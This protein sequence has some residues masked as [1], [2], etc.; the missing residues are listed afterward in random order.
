[1]PMIQL[2]GT[3]SLNKTHAVN[4]D[5][6]STTLKAIQST[7]GSKCCLRREDEETVNG[8]EREREREKERERE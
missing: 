1:M 2:V 5:I 4:A 6:Y 8:R 7:T 3:F